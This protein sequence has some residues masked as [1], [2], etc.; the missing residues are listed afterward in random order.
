MKSTS[1]LAKNMRKCKKHNQTTKFTNKHSKYEQKQKVE[2]MQLV[3]QKTS[4]E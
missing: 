4:A 3:L 1:Q 2:K